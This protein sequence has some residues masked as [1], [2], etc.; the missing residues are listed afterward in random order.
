MTELQ[1]TSTA[2]ALVRIETKLDQVLGTGTD[3][4]IRIR[5]LERGR[6]PLPALTVLISLGSGI[7]AFMALAQHGS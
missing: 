3:H 5:S 1:D 6:W 7:A 4:E 2:T